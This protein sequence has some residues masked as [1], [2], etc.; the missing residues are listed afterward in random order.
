MN[1][2]SFNYIICT[3]ELYF[4]KVK[5]SKPSYLPSFGNK[6]DTGYAVGKDGQPNNDEGD[7]SVAKARR[8]PHPAA[9]WSLNKFK[10]QKSAD[11][12][13]TSIT[14]TYCTTF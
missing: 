9:E 8:L 12:R 2:N 3:Y 6:K 11:G 5:S 10:A 7:P 14:I 13:Y 4:I 1:D